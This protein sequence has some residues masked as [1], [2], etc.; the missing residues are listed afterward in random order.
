MSI[1]E[2]VNILHRTEAFGGLGDDRLNVLAFSGERIRFRAGDI[3]CEAGEGAPRCHV[4]VS[5]TLRIVDP[6]E[7]QPE[8]TLGRAATIGEYGLITNQPPDTTI[9]AETDGEALV[10]SR[11]LFDRVIG[12]FPDIA[13]HMREAM[14]TRLGHMLRDLRTLEKRLRRVEDGGRDRT[15]PEPAHG[16]TAAPSP[17][18]RRR[19]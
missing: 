1:S 15:P 11:E 18:P 2:A 14:Q 13:L 19:R 12:D 9:M 16:P 6:S 5:G 7:Q 8:R 3:L 10:I 4:I 17:G